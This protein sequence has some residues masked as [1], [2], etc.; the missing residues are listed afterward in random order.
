VV[1]P[2]GFEQVAIVELAPYHY[3][4]IFRKTLGGDG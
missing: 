4:S 1:E 2:A 3:G